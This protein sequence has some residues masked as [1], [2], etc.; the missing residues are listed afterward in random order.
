MFNVVRLEYIIVPFF[1]D[2]NA[3]IF[4]LVACR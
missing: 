3:I 2:K 1:M 4:Q